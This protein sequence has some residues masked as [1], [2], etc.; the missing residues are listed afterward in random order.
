MMVLRYLGPE[1][2]RSGAF[3]QIN[4]GLLI[5]PFLS[6]EFLNPTFSRQGHLGLCGQLRP[7]FVAREKLFLLNQPYSHNSHRIF[8]FGQP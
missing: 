6:P 8:K 5:P 1:F 7:F 3:E 4:Q 2:S